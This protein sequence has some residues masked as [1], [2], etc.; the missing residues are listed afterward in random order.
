MIKDISEA[1][2]RL[3]DYGDLDEA[4][5]DDII[6]ELA[7]SDVDVYNF[8]R[9]EWMRESEEN[10]TLVE[11]AIDEFGWEGC[12][13]NLDSAIGLAQ[14]CANQHLLQEAW[15]VMKKHKSIPF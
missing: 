10:L 5:I 4:K 8:D 11:E 14:Y 12:D 15:E 13:K 7:D 9:H 6:T 2:E 1:K 3:E